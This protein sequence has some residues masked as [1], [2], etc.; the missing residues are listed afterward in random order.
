MFKRTKV[1][2]T[3]LQSVLR[4]LSEQGFIKKYNLGHMNVDYEISD[5]GKELLESLEGL[6]RLLME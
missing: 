1:S 5:R 3:T 4:E 2:H 6:Y